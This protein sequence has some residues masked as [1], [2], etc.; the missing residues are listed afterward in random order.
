MQLSIPNMP[1]IL[2]YSVLG[3]VG[4]DVVL[5]ILLAVRGDLLGVVLVLAIAAGAYWFLGRHAV[6]IVSATAAAAAGT[7]ILLVA[8]LTDLLGGHPYYAILF[9]VA[10]AVLGF[11][12]ALLTQGARPAVLKFGGVVAVDASSTA[13]LLAMLDQLR[14]AGV[15]TAEEYSTKAAVLR[16]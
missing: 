15:L 11:I 9:L 4:V 6:T 8:A 1:E 16:A 5:A 3:S 2:T 7:A 10:T 12:L 14:D 13:T